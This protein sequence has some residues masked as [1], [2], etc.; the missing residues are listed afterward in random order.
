MSGAIGKELM[1]QIAQLAIAEYRKAEEKGRKERRDRNL[2]NTKKLVRIIPQLREHSNSSIAEL[3][4]A[5]DDDG[6]DVLIQIM[7]GSGGDLKVDSVKR[8]VAKTRLM[9][10]HVETMLDVY[11]RECE[12]SKR[13]E[14]RRR[15]RVLDMMY[16]REENR[17]E[18]E[19]I[20]KIEHIDKRT[21]YKDI[22]AA[23]ERLS[24][25]IFGIEAY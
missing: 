23:C 25:Y 21:V 18:P 9:L 12:K 8:S 11:R 16:L 13:E 20:A 3:T 17:L 7:N 1:E 22:D 19:E 14:V 5:C 2:R 6:L 10:D 24:Y 15:Y 4:D